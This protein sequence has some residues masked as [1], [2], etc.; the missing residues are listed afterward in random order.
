MFPRAGRTERAEGLSLRAWD[1]TRVWDLRHQMVSAMSF[2][3]LLMGDWP[4]TGIFRMQ[5]FILMNENN[6]QSKCIT[7]E[8]FYNVG[9]VSGN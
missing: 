5:P 4:G 7:G 6:S 2:P 3:Y 1:R 8:R 9:V